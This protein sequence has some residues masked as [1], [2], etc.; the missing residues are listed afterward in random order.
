MKLIREMK[1]VKDRVKS[2][3]E[4][5]PHLRNSDNRLIATV[6]KQDLLN[7]GLDIN[8]LTANAFLME[9]SLSLLT[10]A[11]TIRRIRQKIQEENHELRGSVDG[12][13]KEQAEE[14]RKE[15]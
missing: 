12:L 13:R 3:L 9:Y 5:Y 6:W 7:K 14:V 2:L 15:I 10:N 8:R 11:E 1:L 4:K